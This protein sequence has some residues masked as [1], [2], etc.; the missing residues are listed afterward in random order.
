MGYIILFL[1]FLGVFGIVAYLVDRVKITGQR[2]VKS[3][4]TGPT[5]TPVDVL[6]SVGDCCQYNEE[7]WTV[8]TDCADAMRN[9]VFSDPDVDEEAVKRFM[10]TYG[11]MVSCGNYYVMDWDTY[12]KCCDQLQGMHTDMVVMHPPMPGQIRYPR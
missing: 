3:M 11:P 1:A 9:L 2:V 4:Q 7:I 12:C 10:K 5:K 6:E 8:C